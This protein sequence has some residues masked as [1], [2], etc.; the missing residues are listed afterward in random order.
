MPNNHNSHQKLHMLHFPVEWALI[1]G[2]RAFIR[3]TLVS[4]YTFTLYTL[5]TCT[6]VHKAT[7]NGCLH[8]VPLGV[9]LFDD[10]NCC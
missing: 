8:N 10:G 1:D 7:V 9:R 2:C 4:L 3:F 5:Y 6:V